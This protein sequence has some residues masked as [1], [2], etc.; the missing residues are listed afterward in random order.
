MKIQ[1]SVL[2]FGNNVL[3]NGLFNSFLSFLLITNKHQFL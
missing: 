3:T 2:K 1:E